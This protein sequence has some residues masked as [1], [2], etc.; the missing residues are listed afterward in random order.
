[1]KILESLITCRLHGS[2]NGAKVK[3]PSHGNKGA[4]SMKVS[5]H[6]DKSTRISA[7]HKSKIRM[8]SPYQCL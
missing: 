6:G 8:I 4:S 2:T 1:M 5:V 7:H 3:Q